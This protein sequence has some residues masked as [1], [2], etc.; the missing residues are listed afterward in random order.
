M[1]KYM[2]WIV[3]GCFVLGMVLNNTFLLLVPV[4]NLVYKLYINNQK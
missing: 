2:D 3:L 1:I 4:A